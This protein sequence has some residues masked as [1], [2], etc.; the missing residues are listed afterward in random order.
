M[1]LAILALLTFL[2]AT[3]VAAA[4]DSFT[5]DGQVKQTLT[6]TAA[7]LR[8]MPGVTVDI[9]YEAQGKIQKAQFTGVLLLDVLNKAG[10]VDGEGKGA[11]FRRVV[12]VTGSDDY[13]IAVALGEMEPNLE[14]K[15]V[16]VA[17]ARDGKPVDPAGSVR[18]VVPGDK[19]GA[20][21]VRDVVR[22]TV[23]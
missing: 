17:Y 23:K 4:A 16:L 5:V 10:I 7:E 18:V 1:R 9:S 3:G 12:E 14:G 22:I 20:R 19:H 21:G 6:L 15:Q 2:A 8:K 13:V 11:R